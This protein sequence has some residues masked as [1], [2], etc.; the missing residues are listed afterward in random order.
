[1]AALALLAGCG[2]KGERRA[3]G[4]AEEGG[5]PEPGGTAVMAELADMSKPMP[6]V[7]ESSLDGDLQDVM[8][9]TLLRGAWRDG[10]LAYL[11]AEENPMAL[12]RRYEFL[13]PDSTTLRYHLRSDVKW[14]DGVP[15][16]AKD[17]LYTYH[18]LGDPK[19]A[20]PRQDYVAQ[21]DSVTSENDSTVTFHF[22]K[23]YPE[24]LF[25]SGHGIVPAHV[26]EAIAPEQIR[27][28]R[29][30]TDPTEGRLVVNGAFMVGAWQ[31]GQSITLVPNPHF[32]PAPL[33]E[34]VVIRVIP[35][36]T[37]RLIELQTGNVDF[38]RPIPFDQIANLKA[39]APHVRFER[40]HKRYYDYIGYNPDRLDAFR[41]P[42]IRRALG[43]AIDV[44][45]LIR[46]L[47]MEDYAVP[48]G[49]PYPPIFSDLYDPKMMAPLAYDTVR[50]K[51]ILDEKGWKDTD[52]DGIRDKNGRP[53]RFT[54]LTNAGNSRRADVQQIVQQAWKQIGVDARLQ[55]VETNTFFDRLTKK[56]YDA[57][58]SGWGVGLSPDLT[59]LWSKTSPFNYVSYV[60]PEVTRLMDEA[61]AQPTDAL[62]NP[63]WKRAAE[64]IARDQPYSFLYYYDQVDGVNRRLRGM[65]I[66]TYGAFQNAWEWWIPRAEQ[67]QMPRPA[68]AA[69]SADT[70]AGAR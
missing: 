62:A 31:K 43:M 1:M 2:E 34:Q 15:V 49:G 40:E 22:K 26:Y 8:Y 57:A 28:S 61:L 59:G 66:D 70:G 41:D 14:S 38:T 16:T 17:V 67:R 7:M 4:E 10:R 50:A 48:A 13:A 52:G 47:Q 27:T 65:K 5:T 11:T 19:L 33:L 12:A 54:L 35:E 23:R 21:M 24:M 68:G 30:L 18:V 53:F 37:T 3:G 36:A 29:P 69:A 44:P 58:V 45:G 55:Q 25:H 39:T 32:R 42:E 60:N 9:M 64:L 46:G 20:S 6:L 56:N 63:L 51:Q